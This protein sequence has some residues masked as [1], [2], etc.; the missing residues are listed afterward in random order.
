VQG[1]G[2]RTKATIR[3][4]ESGPVSKDGHRYSRV[5][6]TIE[7]PKRRQLTLNLGVD[8]ATGDGHGV[9][10]KDRPAGA[11]VPV[12]VAVVRD[13]KTQ[14]IPRDAT[15]LSMDLCDEVGGQWT[16][17]ATAP[18]DV[19]VSFQVEAIEMVEVGGS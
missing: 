12:I 17:L 10:G 5:R 3:I 8:V 15:Q 2:K 18:D 19:V 1:R 9:E 6:F 7:A 11:I 4:E 16:V 14:P 13:G